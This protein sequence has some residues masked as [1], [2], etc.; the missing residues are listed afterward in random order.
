MF[1]AFFFCWGDL[2]WGS[3]CIGVLSGKGS[4]EEEGL[5]DGNDKVLRFLGDCL[6]TDCDLLMCMIWWGQIFGNW[7]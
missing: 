7:G 5:R 2:V 1:A 6:S 4:G 3:V